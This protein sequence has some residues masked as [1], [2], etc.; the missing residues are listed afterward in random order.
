MERE[1]SSEKSQKRTGRKC[2]GRGKEWKE[3]KSKVN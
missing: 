2:I 3:K 1:R